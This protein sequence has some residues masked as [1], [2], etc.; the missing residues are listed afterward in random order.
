VVGGLKSYVHPHDA[1][2]VYQNQML[3]ASQMYISGRTDS[4]L[5]QGQLSGAALA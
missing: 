2:I 4:P 1:S 3:E 5:N